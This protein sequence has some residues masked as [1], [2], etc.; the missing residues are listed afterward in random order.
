MSQGYE[1]R[2]GDK[3]VLRAKIAKAE[4]TAFAGGNGYGIH[5]R[6]NEWQ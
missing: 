1:H 6:D 3:D 2:N 4:N 5:I